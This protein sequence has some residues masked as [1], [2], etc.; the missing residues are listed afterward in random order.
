MQ[1]FLNL[2]ELESGDIV[3]VDIEQIQWIESRISVVH[4]DFNPRN[5]TNIKRATSEYSAI[6]FNDGSTRC[7]VELYVEIQQLIYHD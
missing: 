2:H 1:R 7:M 5:N 6:K 4:F 3:E